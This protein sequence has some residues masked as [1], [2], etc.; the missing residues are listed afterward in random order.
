M[1]RQARPEPGDR[2][3]WA[4]EPGAWPASKPPLGVCRVDFAMRCG[5]WGELKTRA[6]R[7]LGM[8]PGSGPDQ[9]SQTDTVVPGRRGGAPRCCASR[10]PTVLKLVSDPVTP[11]LGP[12]PELPIACRRILP[13][14]SGFCL[15][16]S[17]H[18]EPPTFR[19]THLFPPHSDSLSRNVGGGLV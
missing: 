3:G 4:P 15:C 19:G 7:T 14:S 9:R 12:L 10:G 18:V 1:W 13:S 5:R 2:P 11:L 8:G 17:Q 6:G 16:P